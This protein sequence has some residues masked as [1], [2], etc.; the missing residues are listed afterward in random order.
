MTD[1]RLQEKTTTA[2]YTFFVVDYPAH[3]DKVPKLDE[4]KSDFTTV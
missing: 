2:P 1:C 4:E 3:V